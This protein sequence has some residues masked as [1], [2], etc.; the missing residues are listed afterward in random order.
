MKNTLPVSICIPAYN[1]DKNIHG[2]L[3]GLAKQ[4]TDEVTINKIV[5]VCSGC[6]DDTEKIARIFAES[7]PRVVVITEEKRNGKASAINTFLATVEDPVVVIQSADTVP[8]ED[9]IEKLCAPFITNPNLGMTG[10]APIPMND[11]K[12]FLGF[13]IHA[14][15]WFHRNIPRFGEII[16]FRSVINNISATTAVDEAYIQAQMIKKGMDVVHIDEARV[17][18]KGPET[19][20]DLIKQRRRIFNGHARLHK[21]Q[22]IKINN[23]TKSS[24]HLL[25]FKFRLNSLKEAVWLVGGILIEIWARILGAWDSNVRNIN[26]FIWDTANTTKNLD[27]N[28]DIAE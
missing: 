15:W 8:Y 28:E 26:P 20:K 5:V 4:I 12:T 22:H 25:L 19:V 2:L 3:V 6:T 1:E 17:H 21:D 7:D 27:F 11:P 14:W 9:C 10:G 16:A 13:I 18:N 23:M 24:A